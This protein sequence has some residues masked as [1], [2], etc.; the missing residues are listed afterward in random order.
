MLVAAG[1]EVN[2]A[3]EVVAE[4]AE[5][6]LVGEK[7]CGEGKKLDFLFGDV[8]ANALE[9]A[10]NV[11]FKEV[12][13]VVNLG[14]VFFVF[15]GV[16]SSETNAVTEVV[17]EGAGHNGVKVDNANAL[18]RVVVDHD[19]VELGIVVRN[20]ERDLTVCK[21]INDNVSEVLALF[22]LFDF[23][24]AFA[25][26]AC[27]VV[28]E[29][30]H[31][32]IV[33]GYGVVEVRNG[34]VESFCGIIGEEV[35]IRTESFCRACENAGFSCRAL[36]SGSVGDEVVKAPCAGFLGSQLKQLMDVIV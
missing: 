12:E 18:V 25:S 10:G 23:V 14:E 19:V 21:R 26:S 22:D 5:N 34:F 1:L 16:T 20:A 15:C 27:N 33:S 9:E 4:E 35:L 6:E 8:V 3:V 36:V 32:V 24:S 17:K 31:E 7:E 30:R 11:F 13:T 29:S 28:F 2:I